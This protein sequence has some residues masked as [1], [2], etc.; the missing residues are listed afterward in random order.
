MNQGLTAARRERARLGEME[1]SIMAKILYV[2]DEPNNVE[3]VARLL[4]RKQHTVFIAENSEDGI[5]QA[6]AEQPDLILMD[7]GIPQ[8]PGGTVSFEI[9]LNTTR[10]IKRDAEI[11]RIPVLALTAS[12]MPTQQ[13]AMRE[14]GCDGVAMKPFEFA[15]LLAE[16]D[17]LLQ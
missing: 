6:K 17:R 13:Q 1:P 15:E 2:E 11:S 10:E 3:I 4:T 16:I 8:V 12:T 9:G 14:A 7:M 5:K